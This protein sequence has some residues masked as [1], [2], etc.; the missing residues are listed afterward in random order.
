VSPPLKTRP[1]TVWRS[2]HDRADRHARLVR[3][4]EPLRGEGNQRRHRGA[5]GVAR[6][7]DV[8]QLRAVEDLLFQGGAHVGP[9]H[10]EHGGEAG[11]VGGWGG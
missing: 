6:D 9:H 7:G 1:R 10:V 5:E 8:P 4:E 3:V 2:D 11:C